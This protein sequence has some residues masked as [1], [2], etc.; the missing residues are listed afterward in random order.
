MHSQQNI[1]FT[2]TV[3]QLVRRTVATF[4]SDYSLLY[5]MHDIS[6]IEKNYKSV[7]FCFISIS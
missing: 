4:H 5:K 1:K 7:S 2:Q 6:E 3:F